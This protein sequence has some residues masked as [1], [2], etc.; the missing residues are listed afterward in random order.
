MKAYE[1]FLKY[2]TI[3]TTSNESNE[4]CPSTP[5]QKVFGQQLVEEL[6]ALGVL[7]ARMDQHG[8]VYA[9]IPAKGKADAPAIGFIAHMD[10]SNAVPGGP[11]K[12]SIIKDYDGGDITLANG[13]V[14]SVNEFSFLPGLKGQDLIVTDGNTLLGGDDK[15]GVA[16]IMTMAER[17]MGADAPDH[18][19]ICIGFTPD[20]EIGRGADLFDVPGFGA[21]YAYTVDGGQAG[22]LEYENFNA[23]SLKVTVHGVNIHPGT[24]KNKMVNACLL[25]IE[26]NSMLPP[27]ETPSHTEGYEG[28]YHLGSMEGQEEKTV[29][30]YI[31][32][33]HD[34]N[35]FEKRKETA[36][37]IAKYMNDKYGAGTLEAEIMDS[38]YNMK[39]QLADHMYIVDK[40]RAAY[41]EMGITPIT[42]PIRG[43]TDGSRLSFMGLP[44]PN[45]GTGGY[46]CHGRR[47]LASIQQM[48]MMADVLVR[49]AQNA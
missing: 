34:R 12:A 27:W 16:E 25:A 32:R 17:L 19:K 14:T 13:L 43:G 45:L 38:Y 4:N 29:L 39:Q 20:E 48:E 3:D 36:L 7:D 18:G 1:R 28:F 9:S 42:L 24:S 5:N 11:C 49:I 8:Y 30:R 6:L 21:E 46:N 41:E 26:Y 31:I 40:A 37:A 2:V 35:L 23:A 10:T 15:A 33:D 47:E 22:E 44:C